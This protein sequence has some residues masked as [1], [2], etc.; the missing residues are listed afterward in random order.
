MSRSF[1]T[2]IDLTQNQLLNATIQNLASA[3]A[4]PVEGQ[5]YC[6]TSDHNIYI[7]L[8][9][10]WETWVNAALLAAANGVATLN[11]S[12]T[13]VQNPANAQTTSAASKIPLADGSGKLANTW[14]NTGTG[15]GL[16]ADTVDGQHGTYY[17]NRT[18]HSGTQSASTI[19]D[20]DTQVRSSRLDQMAVPTGSVS[21]N[22]QKITNLAT[23]TAGA[24]AVTK[25][26]VDSI[27]QGLDPKASVKAATTVN[28][29]LSGAQTIDGV[30]VVA[31]DRVLVKNQTL[32][33]NN[34]I[35]IVQSGAW[36][37]ATDADA[38]SELVSAYVFV[39]EGTTNADSGWI[40]SS[41]TGGTLNTTPI[42]WTQFSQAGVLTA[43]N[44]GSGTLAVF[45]QKN[46][47]NFEFR[48]IN[49]T[50]TI[51]V[52]ETND[53]LTFDVIQ[54]GLSLNSLGG[55]PLS[56]ANGGTNATT[57]AAA[58]TSLGFTT[59]YSADVGDNT[60]TVFVITHNLGTRDVLVQVRYASGTYA[61]VETDVEMTSTNTIT[62]RFNV[63]P[64]TSQFR[65][66]IIG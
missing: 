21:L 11:G 12:S 30:S 26:Y 47:T 34:G 65:V 10:V 14:L 1:L 62:L 64:T 25:D 43:S 32:S 59:K 29:T 6:N 35:Y 18:N 42:T 31:T 63:A 9:G 61:L 40:C 16:D 41:N 17:L 50:T 46:G 19:S 7:Y 36:T 15:N 48:T 3:P 66:T 13:V 57:T 51:N 39:E 54:S 44:I 45:K 24:D 2:N 55:A 38:W 53:I 4:T 23:P 33:Q 27:S 28:I 8:N 60:N 56:V 22:S 5:I 52:T 49:D 58:K 37:R 20:F